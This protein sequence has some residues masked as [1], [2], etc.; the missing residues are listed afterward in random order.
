MDV[1]DEFPQPENAASHDNEITME[2]TRRPE[3]NMAKEAETL[4]VAA[5]ES[6]RAGFLPT[7]FAG[8]SYTWQALDLMA[9]KNGYFTTRSVSAGISIAI[10][11]GLYSVGNFRAQKA[12]VDQARDQVRGAQDGVLM[13]VRQSY[14]SLVN[15]RESLLGQKENVET[16]A[17]NLKI[18][19]DRY[20][21]GLLSL[22]E[23]KD[24]ELSLIDASTQQIKAL[25][26]YN[27]SLISLNR[28]VG[29][30]S[31]GGK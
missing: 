29:L 3:L 11:D 25:Y 2:L 7:I 26:D 27:V 19:Q 16:A 31:D 24:A 22:L 23:L 4:Q 18:A 28:A 15:A 1:K 5:R 6:A 17:E 13:E 8:Y 21:M 12:G 10:F 9:D 20:K 30:P 14:Y